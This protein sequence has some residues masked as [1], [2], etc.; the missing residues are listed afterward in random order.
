MVRDTRQ[1]LIAGGTLIAF[2]LVLWGLQ[3]FDAIG[4]SAFFL[5]AGGAFLAAYFAKSQYGFLIPGCILLGIGAGSIGADSFLDFGT[6]S[7]LGLGFG[8]LA[9]FL[10][11]LLYER[12]TDWWPL[13]PGLVLVLLGAGQFDE[14]VRFMRRNWPLA[15]VLAGVLV[16]IGAFGRK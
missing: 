3:R 16:M 8:F 9:I 15:L 10:I 2:G 1:R 5:L 14:M 6:P 7:L 11:A 13:I 12:R 4:H